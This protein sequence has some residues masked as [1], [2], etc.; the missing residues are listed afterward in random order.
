MK[1]IS[2]KT[3]GVLI[4]FL[5]VNAVATSVVV[6]ADTVVPHTSANTSQLLEKNTTIKPSEVKQ[7]RTE[8]NAVTPPTIAS[9]NSQKL[10]NK[11]SVDSNILKSEQPA[12]KVA[13]VKQVVQE[14]TKNQK[15]ET[16]LQA[17]K[18]VQSSEK[19][20]NTSSQP[21]S[22]ENKNTNKPN[23]ANEVDMKNVVNNASTKPT[24]PSDSKVYKRVIVTFDQVNKEKVDEA[25][26][27]I[28]GT[29]IKLTY[30]SLFNG[31]SLAVDEKEI[32]KIGKIKEI[33]HI[34]AVQVL[35]PQM[36]TANQ[37]THVLAA[38]LKA[39]QNSK[40]DGRGLLI[41][42]IDS[43]VDI[44]HPA[45]R[46]DE[47]DPDVMAKRRIK[48]IKAPYTNKVPFAYNYQR[49]D[50]L[51]LKDD[52]QRPHGMHLAGILSGNAKD[53]FK[54]VAPNAQLLV[55]KISTNRE[56][57][58]AE[59]TGSDAVFH[60]MEDAAKR[61]ADVISLSFGY[62]GTG[63]PGE[64]WYE[65][66]KKV[67]DKGVI[68]VAAMGNY[69]NSASSTTYD[70]VVD[71]SLGT[72]DTAAMV[73][74]A[75][76]DKVIGVGSVQNSALLLDVL[77]VGNLKLGYAELGHKSQTILKMLKNKTFDLVY[78]GKGQLKKDIS[79]EDLK[80]YTGKVIVV[81][82]GGEG[83]KDKLKRF[84]GIAKGVIMINEPAYYSSGNFDTHPMFDYHYDIPEGKWAISLSKKD[85]DQ[86]I[87]YIKKN[88]TAKLEF[89]PKETF[90][91]RPNPTISGFSSWGV[92]PDL[93]LKPDVV[94][95][96]EDIYSTFNDGT[97]GYMSGTSMATPQ[98]AAISA[99]VKSKVAEIMALKLPML[100]G[101]TNVDLTKIVL[102][103]TSQP[104]K[105]TLNKALEISPR[106]QGAGM[107]NL[108]KALANDVL[109]FGDKTGSF[110][111]KEIKNHKR[112]TLKLVNTGQKRRN[113][114]IE[115][116]A[117]LTTKI[118]DKV[119]NQGYENVVLKAVHAKVIE[120]ATLQMGKV[121]SLA[122]QSAIELDID[123]EIKKPIQDFAE[124]Y[125]YFKTL[126]KDG[127]DISAPYM[128]FSGTWDLEP[129]FDA[130]MWDSRSKNKLTTLMQATLVGHGT[131]KF[132]EI[133]QEIGS[134]KV[135]PSL[136]T[137]S[138]VRVAPDKVVRVAPRFSLLRSASDFDLSIVSEAK[139]DSPILRR[140]TVKHFVEKYYK[141]RN[142]E[143]DSYYDALR[144][145]ESSLVW[146]GK[147]YDPK[148][149]DFKAAKPG[150]YYFK[151]RARSNPTDP[152][153]VQY[154]PILIDNE[155]PTFSLKKVNN[156]FDILTHDNHRVK[157]VIVRNKETQ[158]PITVKKIAENHY[159]IDELT[160][161]ESDLDIKV[162]DYAG[163]SNKEIALSESEE[164]SEKSYSS[165]EDNTLQP[166][167]LSH[168]NMKAQATSSDDDDIWDDNDDDLNE[169]KDFD[170]EENI[171]DIEDGLL[172]TR[173]TVY[174]IRTVNK[175]RNVENESLEHSV[176]LLLKDG[177]RA[178]IRVVNLHENAKDPKHSDPYRT[179]SNPIYMYGDDSDTFKTTWVKFMSGNNIMNLKVYNKNDKLVFS[180]GYHIT[181]DVQPPKLE[182]DKTNIEEAADKDNF[183]TGQIYAQNGEIEIKGHVSD[184]VKG[185]GLSINGDSVDVKYSSGEFISNR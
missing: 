109:V 101:L 18:Q 66:I 63:R 40:V 134:K 58:S 100:A 28:P 114:S 135:N 155:R 96:G 183:I 87:D 150:L 131:N 21:S 49:G 37:W 147:F 35:K 53:G 110:S 167:S 54:G 62:L 157:E 179:V 17:K 125:L 13:G 10:E 161:R 57:P 146:D 144:T 29:R 14:Q 119:T 138:N 45:M 65:T 31:Y 104:L 74:V 173:E 126:D 88:K 86:L 52:V 19:L 23:K 132:Y 39:K 171:S 43:G 158:K 85:G 145:T 12:H 185:W 160:L 82:R 22:E 136:F 177:Y 75:A 152:Y 42:T 11:S 15:D 38:R 129:I 90:V 123:L 48:D 33:K 165:E 112:F 93:H 7:S 108:E 172:L 139:D 92:T 115:P 71:N 4:A 77:K 51:E 46:L 133:G 99:L 168:R 84:I 24:P 44:H 47:N 156:G 76:V 70:N 94:A 169:E 56:D 9:S 3:T 149:G 61:G 151:L 176:S 89:L 34:E 116:G 113:F 69:G 180:R 164:V 64:L 153:Q 95:P 130:P 184:N 175:I 2:L 81:E 27:A 6:D 163:N 79:E 73:S 128:G 8:S 105:D 103:N 72:K 121:I 140:I 26:K 20:L 16:S 55:Y 102:M 68:V 60:A 30:S 98:V 137:M 141:S 127:Q 143:E 178:E 83:V 181:V 166:Q 154:L 118:V 80:S 120:G 117:I 97:Y 41:A 59:W 36:F 124:G 122:P 91:R 107:V 25:L 182:L 174:S 50:N 111:I 142:E 32:E 148:T 78:V 170:F 106:R 1:R 162:A 159:H 67:T 5:A